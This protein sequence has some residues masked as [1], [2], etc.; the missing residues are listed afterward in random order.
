M[1]VDLFLQTDASSS[2]SSATLFT[3]SSFLSRKYTPH[4]EKCSIIYQKTQSVH[5]KRTK[6]AGSL[7]NLNSFLFMTEIYEQT[8]FLGLKPARLPL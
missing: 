4:R 8:K 2:W 1:M 5:T 6:K 3:L 7:R